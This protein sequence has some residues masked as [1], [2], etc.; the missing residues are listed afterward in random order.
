M[1]RPGKSP[2]LPGL[3]ALLCALT[4]LGCSGSAATDP[5]DLPAVEV[6]AGA[7][8]MGGPELRVYRDPY[9][10]VGWNSS[11]RL[12][13]QLHDHVAA[14]T[15]GIKAY[16]AAGYQVVSLMD[17][18][19][20]PSLIYPRRERLWPPERFF[21][22]AFRG[23]LSN[24]DL[25]LPNGEEIGFE[26]LTSPFLETYIEKWEPY[27]RPRREPYQYQSTQEAIELIGRSGGLAFVAH[28]WGREDA[29]LYFRDYSGVEIYSA[30]AAVQQRVGE[31]WRI[32][33]HA[34]ANEVML[35]LWDKILMRRPNVLG[36]AVNDHY[37]PASSLAPGDTLKDSGKILVLAPDATLSA[38]RR[39]IEAGAFLA[40][41][42]F[43]VDKGQYPEVRSIEVSSH[44]V[45]IDTDGEVR[46]I[47]QGGQVATGS[48]I[49]FNRL[50][51]G[52][53]RAEIWNAHGSVVFT[54]PFV[55]RPV[56]DANGD[57]DV[58]RG[59]MEL[60]MD[61]SPE[62]SPVTLLDACEAMP[63]ELFADALSNVQ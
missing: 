58:D 47:S 39:A 24:I 4:V 57:G 26:H 49:H 28:P 31:N 21:S 32:G 52:Y 16:D 8:P 36:V 33:G 45:H 20:V 9:R 14:D 17:Y 42:D 63:Q 27:W 11:L 59:D 43:G 19:G 37:G 35:R 7:S 3:D 38:V 53:L 1:G 41:R 30:Y 15:A 56:G 13:T 55:L 25:F 5:V 61:P 29:Y 50:T 6:G 51:S 48:R 22:S 44:Y 18:S 10:D 60:C 12:L 54:Q 62:L 2:G 34:N 46:W 23:R 40:I